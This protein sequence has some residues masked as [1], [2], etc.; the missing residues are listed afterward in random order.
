MKSAPEITMI[1]IP[2]ISYSNLLKRGLN[3]EI[4]YICRAIGEHR[5]DNYILHDREKI[6]RVTHLKE[7]QN[8]VIMA[9]LYLLSDLLLCILTIL[10][11][12]SSHC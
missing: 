10:N 5:C 1:T 6:I 3:A 11:L 12:L 7:L 9:A 8:E 4:R 2:S